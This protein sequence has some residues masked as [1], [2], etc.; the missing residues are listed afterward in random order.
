MR[1]L[2]RDEIDDVLIA[3][4]SLAVVMVAYAFVASQRLRTGVDRTELASFETVVR[5]IV[6]DNERDAI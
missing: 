1:N 5:W 2:N 6:R 4:R 3:S